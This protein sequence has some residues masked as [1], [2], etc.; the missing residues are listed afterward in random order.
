MARHTQRGKDV[1][2][3][4][5]AGQ[6]LIRGKSGTAGK[7]RP[8]TRPQTVKRDEKRLRGLVRDYASADVMRHITIVRQ[9]IPANAVTVLAG[10][11]GLSKE[12]LA[13][14]LDISV[15]TLNRRARQEIAL[16]TPDSER[17]AGVMQLVGMVERWATELGDGAPDGFAPTAWLG[18]WLSTAN[19]ALGGAAPL[20]LLDT[21]EG[22]TLVTQVL[23]S[24]ESG[25]F[26]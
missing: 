1:P 23:G 14:A 26:W 9:G 11:L 16:S 3:P 21:A 17:V 8:G 6:L 20:T 2:K 10:G 13:T 15:P 19:P 22:R 7:V 24:L 18:E 25:T 12:Q 5:N 4:K